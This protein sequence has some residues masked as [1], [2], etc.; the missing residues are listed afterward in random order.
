MVDILGG[1]GEAILGGLISIL[2]GI[3]MIVMIVVVVVVVPIRIF[4]AMIRSI[5][6][7]LEEL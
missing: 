1:I 4:F 6:R 7:P 2:F 5:L 3:L